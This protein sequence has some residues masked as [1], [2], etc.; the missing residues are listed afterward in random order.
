VKQYL[1]RLDHIAG[2]L[3]AWLFAIALGLAVLDITVLMVKAILAMPMP[4]QEI[5]T[6]A[7][8]HAALIPAPSAASSLLG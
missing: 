8:D 2:R 3:N 4:S 1:L 6:P 5:V 7:P